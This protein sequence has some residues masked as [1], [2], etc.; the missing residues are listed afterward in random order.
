ML[1]S[2]LTAGAAIF[3]AGAAFIKLVGDYRSDHTNSLTAA[4]LR[5]SD[6]RHSRRASPIRM[7]LQTMARGCWWKQPGIRTLRRAIA[8]DMVEHWDHRDAE[9]AP[10]AEARTGS[11]GRNPALAGW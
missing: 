10:D 4:R 9:S 7:A 5:R 3:A 6:P 2:G 11:P 8:R 1:A